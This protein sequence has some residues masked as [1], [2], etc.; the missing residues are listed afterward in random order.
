[1]EFHMINI[2]YAALHMRAQTEKTTFSCKDDCRSILEWG[3]GLV[4][5]SRLYPARAL[6]VL[7][8]F[9]VLLYI[10]FIVVLMVVSLRLCPSIGTIKLVWWVE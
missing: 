3:K 1:M 5:K 2:T 7:V 6:V 4:K 10:V 8:L 9:V